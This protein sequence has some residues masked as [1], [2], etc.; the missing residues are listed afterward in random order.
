MGGLQLVFKMFDFFSL[1]ES[2]TWTYIIQKQMTGDQLEIMSFSINSRN[3]LC[4]EWS[5]DRMAD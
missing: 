5:K 1:N 2:C 4:Q 3:C